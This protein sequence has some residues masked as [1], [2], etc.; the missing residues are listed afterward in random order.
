MKENPYRSPGSCRSNTPSRF[1]RGVVQFA[2][3]L[4]AAFFL[5]AWV[6]AFAVLFAMEWLMRDF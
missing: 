5:G 1:R 3:M 4:C 6:C 2:A